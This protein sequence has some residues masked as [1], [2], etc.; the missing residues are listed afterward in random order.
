MRKRPARPPAR[1]RA[2]RT[3]RRGRNARMWKNRASGTTCASAV[4]TTSKTT[5]STGSFAA[6]TYM[7][8]STEPI[9]KLLSPSAS[10]P[11]LR[12][13]R[14]SS[15]HNT[16][17][18]LLHESSSDG[19]ARQHD[20]LSFV[21]PQDRYVPHKKFLKNNPMQ[22]SVIK[23]EQK[24]CLKPIS[25][26]FEEAREAGELHEAKEVLRIKLPAD[27]N[28]ALP[29]NPGEEPFD[30]PAPRISP[31]SASILRGALAAI[32]SVRCNHLDTV[33]A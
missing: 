28:A 2:L 18:I 1:K 20:T 16:N 17:L 9:S 3:K 6:R 29:L 21:P 31:K 33:F 8:P 5:I 25:K 22:S 14:T 11:I 7:R 19:F 27:K 12:G 23:N 24:K 26:S 32:G 10:P 30:Q 13:C 4:A 15:H